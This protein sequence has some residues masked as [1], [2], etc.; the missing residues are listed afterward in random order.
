MLRKLNTELTT[1]KVIAEQLN[2][3]LAAKKA[4]IKK[5][6]QEIERQQTRELTRRKK[7]LE[8]N[9][10]LEQGIIFQNKRNDAIKKRTI[11]LNT[12][13]K[14]QRQLMEM[15][16]KLRQEE[17]E[18][19]SNRTSQQTEQNTQRQ[20]EEVIEPTQ[21]VKPV[22]VETSLLE[23]RIAEY[24]G[25]LLG[26][27]NALINAHNDSIGYSFKKE[28]QAR[29]ARYRQNHMKK[30]QAQEAIHPEENFQQLN[31]ELTG[32]AQ[33]LAAEKEQNNLLNDLLTKH[34]NSISEKIRKAE[35]EHR[36]ISRKVEELTQKLDTERENN[37]LLKEEQHTLSIQTKELIEE[38][39]KERE[40]NI[41]LQEDNYLLERQRD[42]VFGERRQKER[43]QHTI[44]MEEERRIEVFLNTLSSEREEE[45]NQSYFKMLGVRINDNN[46][47][48]KQTDE[49]IA[50]LTE[51]SLPERK[52]ALDR[53]RKYLVVN[54]TKL[55]KE[56]Q[57]W[58]NE[59]QQNR[60]KKPGLF[61]KRD[62]NNTDN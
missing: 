38:L 8:D 32:L 42:L 25:D 6:T 53:A 60:T 21:E 14:Q 40:R 23:D 11:L 4:S 62:P 19:I 1:K 26:K 31:Q 43:A 50:H 20:N 5:L 12:E 27:A 52:K 46:T 13:L 33:E 54:N 51:T 41:S 16:K 57:T 22:P 24:Q 48:I 30:Q 35:E 56:M 7:T 59:R 15:R 34:M 3:Q 29:R 55:Q 18:N 47:A 44:N 49:R 9:T 61:K 37:N 36:T 10:A 39:D 28:R 58:M 45:P 2:N 17:L